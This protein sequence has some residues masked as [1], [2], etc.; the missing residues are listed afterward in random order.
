MLKISQRFSILVGLLA[1]A[2]LTGCPVQKPAEVAPRDVTPGT[3]PSGIADLRVEPDAGEDFD[4]D[5]CRRLLSKIADAGATDIHELQGVTVALDDFFAG[6]R[7][8]Y[9]M[10]AN[11]D[12]PSPY[13]TAQGWYDLLRGV[14]EHDGVRDVRVAITMIEPSTDGRLGMWPY[15]DTVWISSTLD[16]ATVTKLVAPLQPSEVT[17]STADAGDGELSPLRRPS[18]AEPGTTWYCVWWD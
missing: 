15:S 14:R 8:R 18:P 17:D 9:S 4:A 3:T 12:P 11:V 13:D 10:A 6:N 5:A 1:A 2:G 16:L 7:S